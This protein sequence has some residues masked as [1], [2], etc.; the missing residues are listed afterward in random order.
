MLAQIQQRPWVLGLATTLLLLLCWQIGSQSGFLDRQLIPSAAS[1]LVRFAAQ[2][3]DA[4]FYADL[5]ATCTRV[6]G[7]FAVAAIIGIGVGLIMGTS[8]MAYRTLHLTIEVLR[9]VPA[10]ALVPIA[11]VA[12]G[13]GTGM[14]IF[15]VASAA[16]IPILLS[17]VD[18]VRSVDP[19][20]IDTARTFGK[21]KGLLF[22]TVLLP[23][24]LPRIMTGLRVAMAIALV[25][26]ISSEMIMSFNGL[27]RRVVVAQHMLQITDVYAGIV[28]LAL[29]GFVLNR[30]ILLAER[31]LIG[32]HRSVSAKT[33]R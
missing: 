28:T 1:V 10:T 3:T 22:R 20:L 9:P 18:G 31:W 29:L 27:G 30:A 23:A 7:G 25:V 26:G 4:G 11:A 13:V 19:V 24:A 8:E 6:I 16:M 21:R 2:W 33:W 12:F 14:H 17:T 15:I 32:W 5:A